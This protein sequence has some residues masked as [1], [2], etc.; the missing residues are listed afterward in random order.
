MGWWVNFLEKIFPTDKSVP[1]YA[2]TVI[3]DIPAEIY[4]AELAVHTAVSMISNAI[5]RAEKKTFI[6]GKPIKNRDYYLL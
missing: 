6:G 3:V 1:G 4:Y 2:K 5:S